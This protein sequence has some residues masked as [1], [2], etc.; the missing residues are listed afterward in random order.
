LNNTAD[1]RQARADCR[2]EQAAAA[3]SPQV[4][5]AAAVQAVVDAA[6]TQA[7]AQ[8]Q[9]DLAAANAANAL[10]LHQAIAALPVAPAAGAVAAAGAPAA[11]FALTPGS[12]NP[13]QPWDYT[14]SESLKIY[15]HASAKLLDTPFNG[16]NKALKVLLVATGHRGRHMDGMNCSPS[17][18]KWLRPQ[19][20]RIC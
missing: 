9:A 3:A 17:Q 13:G 11:V 20:T 4:M 6:V 2:A 15:T 7:A 8:H 10:A 18:I 5:D 19:Q 1:D 16:G 14:M 12:A